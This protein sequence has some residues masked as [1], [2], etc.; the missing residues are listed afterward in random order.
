M[1]LMLLIETFLFS[2]ASL[3]HYP[4]MIG[5][6]ALVL[7]IVYLS[8]ALLRERLARRRGERPALVAFR[9]ALEQL[10]KETDSRHRELEI[11]TLLQ[12]TERVLRAPV[13]KARFVVRA[14]P[15]MGLMGTLIPMGVALAALAGGSMPQ[16]A[17]LMVNAFNSAVVGLGT[18]VAAFALALVRDQWI[19][20]D[21]L[22]M[23]YLS[24]RALL[25]GRL[26]E[27]TQESDMAPGAVA[28]GEVA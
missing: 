22:A 21:L 13:D 24:E 14:G 6:V 12:D 3:I 27:P 28:Q 8:G 1:S 2:V 23:R 16:M 5:L 7:Y 20:A 25:D 18:G 11:E 17:Q 26:P 4:V 19:Q 9:S 15:G 10:L